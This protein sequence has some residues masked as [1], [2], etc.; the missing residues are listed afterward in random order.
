[1]ARG[2]KSTTKS[3]K[4]VSSGNFTFTAVASVFEEFVHNDQIPILRAAMLSP[5]ES[6]GQNEFLE[7][8]IQKCWK[9]GT[10]L[11]TGT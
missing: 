8:A 3:K 7:A 4:R 11:A 2:G 1:M 5:L 6:L 10:K 9:K